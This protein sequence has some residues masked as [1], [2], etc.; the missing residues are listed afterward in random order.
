M[1]LEEVKITGFKS[2]A[3][4]TSIVFKPGIGVIIGNNG[5]GKSNILDA[6]AWALGEND[7]TR[8][9]CTA[10]DD[11]FFS[12]SPEYPPAATAMV[13]LSFRLGREKKAPGVKISRQAD[14]QGNDRY[15]IDDREAPPPV[16]RAKKDELGIADATKTLV[17]QEQIN[18]FLR[19]SPRERYLHLI[20]LLGRQEVGPDLAAGINDCFRRYFQTLIPEGEGKITLVDQ[21]GTPGLVVEAAFPGKGMKNSLLLSGGEKTICSLAANLAIFE[22]LRSPFYLLDEVEPSL[23]WINHRHMQALFRKLAQSRQLVMITHLRSTIE[24]ADTL[25]GIRARPDGTSFTKFYF[26]MNERLLRAY[27]C[28]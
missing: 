10:H 14:R 1:Y 24:L 12:G 11:L 28:C 2:Y 7:L 13:E 4:R 21:D 22:Q 25:H 26:E 23:D 5:V 8:L 9:R 18:D 19:L 17:R 15:L 27:K 6:I 16:Y 3:T 20:S